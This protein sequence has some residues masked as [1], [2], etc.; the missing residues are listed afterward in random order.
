M[1]PCSKGAFKGSMEHAK[2]EYPVCLS[3]KNM[4]SDAK[5]EQKEGVPGKQPENE[6][7][8]KLKKGKLKEDEDQQAPK[9]EKDSEPKMGID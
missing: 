3:I 2:V 7:K 5:R 8:G 4:D 9:K 1:Q 6:T